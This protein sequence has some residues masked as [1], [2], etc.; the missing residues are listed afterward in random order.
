MRVIKGFMVMQPLSDNTPQA[1]AP[2]GEL[3][4]Y[5]KT[6]TRDLTHYASTNQSSIDWMVF[7]S[8]VDGVTETVPVGYQD[9]I[10]PIAQ[11]LYDRGV[12]E[13]FTRDEAALV[14]DLLNQ[15]SSDVTQVEAGAM[16][17]GDSDG[18]YLPEWVSFTLRNTQENNQIK[19]WLSD[20]AFRRQYD[21]FEILVVPPLEPVD[22]LLRQTVQVKADLDAISPTDQMERI[23]AT[24]GD[25]PPTRIRVET[26]EWSHPNDEQTVL[27]TDWTVILYG[28]AGDTIDSIRKAL[29]DHVLSN[30]QTVRQQWERFIPELFLRREFTLIPLWDN[31]SIPN[32]TLAKGLHSPTVRHQGTLDKARTLT[33]EY[34]DEHVSEVLC[35]SVASYRSM[36]FLAIGGPDNSDLDT[37]DVFNEQFK[38]YIVLPTT[39]SE[40][41]RMSKSTQDF[42]VKLTDML[43]VAESM[44]AFSDIPL[45]MSRVERKGLLFLVITHNDIQYLVLSRRS[46]FFGL[47]LE[48]P[49]DLADDDSG[50]GELD[51]EPIPQ[52]NSIFAYIDANFTHQLR[53]FR[54]DVSETIVAID[55]VDAQ[56]MALGQIELT[57]LGENV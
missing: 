27:F 15:F 5:A 4:T 31:F 20:D 48:L 3:S 14:S 21:E 38:D 52:A 49:P 9:T 2:L 7:L 50:L 22:D 10:L 19:F 13:A 41:A 28:P 30:S 35:T 16:I 55:S 24:R 44:D 17:E 36:S 40:F 32:A 51:G 26:F 6:F 25:D 56:P 18:L 43:Q 34:P 47:N 1:V 53:G 33:P 39:S 42:I 11:W 12:A 23:Q 45:T 37:E 46:Y 8:E 54:E 29:I 57:V